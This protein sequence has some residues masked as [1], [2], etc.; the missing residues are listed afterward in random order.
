[1]VGDLMEMEI[2]KQLCDAPQAGSDSMSSSSFSSPCEQKFVSS[3][4]SSCC[5]NRMSQVFFYMIFFPRHACICLILL[6]ILQAK[7]ENII[8]SKEVWRFP[9][10]WS[11]M[12]FVVLLP[13]S[14]VWCFSEWSKD[15]HPDGILS[16]E[17]QPCESGYGSTGSC[18]QLTNSTISTALPQLFPQTSG[19]IASRQEMALQTCTGASCELGF[20]PMDIELSGLPA[21]GRKQ[22]CFQ[23]GL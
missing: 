6:S 5:S 14:A 13:A 21:E 3:T 7:I 2:V 22:F 10:S 15:W 16:T 19:S 18:Q 11:S 8:L 17:D 23:T 20:F 12:L 9:S 4:T 1:M